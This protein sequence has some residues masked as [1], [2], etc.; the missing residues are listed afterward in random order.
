VIDGAPLA[1]DPSLLEPCLTGTIVKMWTYDLGFD[2]P[3]SQ[4]GKKIIGLQPGSAAARA[5]IRDGDAL[6]GYSMNPGDTD[7]P[8]EFRLGPSRRKVSYLP[9][10][11]QVAVLQFAVHDAAA[12]ADVLGPPLP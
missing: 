11:K 9:R 6:S 4:A 3:A 2:W 12:C 10:G 5:G 7:R 1:I 8:V